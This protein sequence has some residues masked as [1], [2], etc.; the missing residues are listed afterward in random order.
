MQIMGGAVPASLEEFARQVLT[1]PAGRQLIIVGNGVGFLFAVVVLVISVVSFPMLVDRNVGAATAVRTS[2]RAVFENPVTMATWG[3]FVAGA[4]V[5]GALPFSSASP[6]SSRARAFDMASVSQGS[7]ALTRSIDPVSLRGVLERAGP[8]PMNTLRTNLVGLAYARSPQ[9]QRR[10]S[11]TLSAPRGSLRVSFQRSLRSGAPLPLL[12][13]PHDR[14]ALG[15]LRRDAPT[16]CS[17]ALIL[18]F[19]ETFFSSTGK[20]CGCGSKAKTSAISG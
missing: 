1:T 16:A 19:P 13:R 7:G 14:H 17:R 4:L 11:M 20:I 8:S 15:S 12:R 10:T 9:L 3:L 6:S 5:L 2:V 18:S